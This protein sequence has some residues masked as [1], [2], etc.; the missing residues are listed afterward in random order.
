MYFSTLVSGKITSLQLK[1]PSGSRAALSSL[2][3]V[4]C[5][6]DDVLSGCQ[7]YITLC[8]RFL[9]VRWR[10]GDTEEEDLKLRLSPSCSAQSCAKLSPLLPSHPRERVRNWPKDSCLLGTPQIPRGRCG[11]LLQ[12]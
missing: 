8:S 7:G 2:K 11:T 9:S 1:F 6:V 4:T 12:L 3:R 10:R 5:T